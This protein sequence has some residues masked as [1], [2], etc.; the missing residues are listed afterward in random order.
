MKHIQLRNKKQINN[1]I[2]S[3]RLVPVQ[4]LIG[5][6]MIYFSGYIQNVLENEKTNTS[7]SSSILSLALIFLFLSFM[8]ATQDICVDGWVL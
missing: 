8:A 5:I 6:Y 4:Y 7:G 1:L 3:L 2:N